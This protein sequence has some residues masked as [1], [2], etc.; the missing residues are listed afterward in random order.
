MDTQVVRKRGKMGV[1]IGGKGWQED[2]RAGRGEDRRE[3]GRMG[4]KEVGMERNIKDERE[5]RWEGRRMNEKMGG[6]EGGG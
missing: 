6:L 5:G 4:G 1:T 2:G 3:G